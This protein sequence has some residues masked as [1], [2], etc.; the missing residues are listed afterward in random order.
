MTLDPNWLT[1]F[2][3]AVFGGGGL[4]AYLSEIRRSRSAIK[5]AETA[6]PAAIL[7]AQAS[8][9]LALNAQAE[10]F[11]TAQR[12]TI[13]AQRETIAAL[14]G[15]VATL[16]TENEQCRGEAAQLQS[17]I[18][19]LEG[20]MRGSGIAVPIRPRPNSLTVIAKGET[21]TFE[22]GRQEPPVAP[23][24]PTRRKRTPTNA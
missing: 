20:I 4:W 24:K 15:R 18:D 3:V 6:T 11:I 10:A 21:T 16:E 2:L 1:T 5:V 9:Q 7:A 13:G 19:G 12:A 8:F 14:E 22:L 17:R 23:V